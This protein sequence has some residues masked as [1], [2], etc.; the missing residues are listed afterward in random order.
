MN[1]KFE[2]AICVRCLVCGESTVSLTVLKEDYY[3]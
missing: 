2:I 3:V 1:V